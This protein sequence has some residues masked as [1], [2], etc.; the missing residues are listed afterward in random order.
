MTI[1]VHLPLYK[2]S[3]FGRIDDN[4]SSGPCDDIRLLVEPL[5]DNVIGSIRDSGTTGRLGGS[6]VRTFK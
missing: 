5:S 3:L 4:A 6:F 2:F 1:T